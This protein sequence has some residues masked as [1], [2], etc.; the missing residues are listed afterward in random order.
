MHRGA[1]RHGG[2]D[3]RRFVKRAG[4]PSQR[5]EPASPPIRRS[6]G[7]RALRRCWALAGRRHTQRGIVRGFDE[8]E[9]RVP[10]RAR[11]AARIARLAACSLQPQPHPPAASLFS[12]P[13]NGAK[14]RAVLTAGARM[15]DAKRN[16]PTTCSA[17]VARAFPFD[18]VAT[19]PAVRRVAPPPAVHVRVALPLPTLSVSRRST[20]KHRRGR[21][22][23]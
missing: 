17:P 21:R 8:G 12:T 6:T 5:L 19:H 3:A 1:D 10:L 15:P 13:G 4:R 22:S 16:P 7:G 2:G 23:T 14:N 11:R 9:F 20:A 18:A